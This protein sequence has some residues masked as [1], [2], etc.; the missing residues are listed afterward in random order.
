MKDKFVVAQERYEAG[1]QYNVSTSID[2]DS[3]LAGYGNLLSY[4]FEYPLPDETIIKLFGS[5]SW[6]EHF[7][8]KGLYHWNCIN[9]TTNEVTL[10]GMRKTEEEMKLM[11]EI[12][13]NF[14]FEI[15][16]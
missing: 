6:D 13:P 9:K 16:K 12:N 10:L 7:K 2:E 1:E 3:I 14:E 4:D 8:L 11:R 5:T 15:I